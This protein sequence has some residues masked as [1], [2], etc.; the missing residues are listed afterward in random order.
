MMAFSRSLRCPLLLGGAT[1][2]LVLAAHTP[3]RADRAVV[4]GVNNYDYLNGANLSGCVPD[5]QLMANTLKKFNFQ[6]TLLTDKDATK[7]SIVTALGSAKT[8]SKPSE[9]FVFYFA[10][11]GTRASDGRSVL[12][13]CDSREDNEANDLK[14]EEL[15]ENV[16]DI[17]ARSRTVLL[18]SCFSGGMARAIG[19]LNKSR[20]HNL[21]TRFH[22]RSSKLIPKDLA[23]VMANPPQNPGSDAAKENSAAPSKICYFTATKRNEQAGE[24][25]FPDGTRHGVFTY[26]LVQ[27][28]NNVKPGQDAWGTVQAEVGG[29]VSDWMDDNQ[30]PTLSTNFVAAPVFDDNTPAPPAPPKPLSVW[31]QY[32]SDHPDDSKLQVRINPDKTTFELGEHLSFVVDVKQSGYLILLE[33]GTSGKVYLRYP[34]TFNV[35]DSKVQAGWARHVPGEGF[36]FTCTETGTERIKAILFSN[37]EL[38]DALLQKFPN[39]ADP[40]KRFLNPDLMKRDLVRV[41]KPKVQD[42]I[43]F[44][45]ADVIFEA[46][47]KGATKDEGNE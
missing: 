45:T 42:A 27:R 1:L 30:H 4:V 23:T 24:D 21:K 34:E 22:A 19:K 47:E 20:K 41:A 38:A 8:A 46:V 33:R 3:A 14:S 25:E 16:N 2:A 17:P 26:Y 5:A 12:L 36:E 11:H 18:D 37:K 29:K 39:D 10:G 7:Q 44:Y 43:P 15:Y 35:D 40:D 9:R 31:D 28:L 13:P 6:V 32:N